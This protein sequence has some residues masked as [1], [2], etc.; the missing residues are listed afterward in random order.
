MHIIGIVNQKGG[1][2]KS[3]ISSNLGAVFSRLNKRVLLIDCDAQGNLSNTFGINPDVFDN[4]LYDVLLNDVNPQETIIP[5]TDNLH[6]LPANDDLAFLSTDAASKEAPY[7]LLDHTVRKLYG[8]YDFIFLDAPPTLSLIQGNI[9]AAATDIIIPFQPEQYSMRGLL[10]TLEAIKG[11]KSEYNPHL[12]ILGILP[13]LVSPRTRL[14]KD[15]LA[16]T[17]QFCESEGLHL[18]E[19]QITKSIQY[20]NY[21]SYEKKPITLSDSKKAAKQAAIYHNIAKEIETIWHDK[22]RA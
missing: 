19:N 6:L 22:I 5:I 16:M 3:S 12:D 18:F 14:H 4:T 21:V 9:L 10:K 20:A 7:M 1:V 11:I 17:G 15:I 13:T 2:L 8:A